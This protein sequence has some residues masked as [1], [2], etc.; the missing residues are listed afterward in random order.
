MTNLQ[1]TGTLM[2]SKDYKERF[3]AEYWQTKFRY[4]K[5]KKL[6]TKIEAGDL[7]S[8]VFE[9]GSCK[10][11]DFKLVA[12][13]EMLRRQQSVMEEYLHILELRAVVEGIDLDV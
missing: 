2:L 5:L 7:S 13:K 4:E 8:K 6:N 1:E 3:K 12:P 10:Y 9:D 11:L